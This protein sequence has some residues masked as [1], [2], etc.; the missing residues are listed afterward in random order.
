VDNVR[1][2]YFTCTHTAVSSIDYLVNYVHSGLSTN[3][4]CPARLFLLC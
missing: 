4:N 2:S 1:S 3:C